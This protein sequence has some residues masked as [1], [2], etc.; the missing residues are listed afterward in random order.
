[1][2]DT[3]KMNASQR[4]EALESTIANLGSKLDSQFQAVADEFN[5]LNQ[6]N[7]ALAKRLNAIIKAGDSGDINNESVKNIIVDEASKELKAQVDMLIEQGL[8]TLNNKREIDDNTFVV[9][10]ETNLEGLEINPR[11]QF[12]VGALQEDAKKIVLGRKAGDSIKD[13]A[14]Q[15]ILIITETYDVK[16]LEIPEDVGVEGSEELAAGA[17]VMPLKKTKKAKKA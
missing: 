6:L 15:Q 3:S 16:Q 8:L 14:L 7:V 12:L 10:R 5:R 9:G 13:E 17:E 11:T 4:L 1:M 2:K